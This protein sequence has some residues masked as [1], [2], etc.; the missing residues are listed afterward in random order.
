LPTLPGLEPKFIPTTSEEEIIPVPA[1]SRVI[2]FASLRPKTRFIVLLEKADKTKDYDAVLKEVLSMSPSA[3]D[4]E[5]RALNTEND[6]HE[7]KLMIRWMQYQLQS[8]SHFDLIQAIMSVFLREQANIIRGH[9]GLK[10]MTKELFKIQKT[11]W[12]KIDA[13]LQSNLCLIAYFT[14]THG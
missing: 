2:N 12:G 3:I 13:L 9:Q 11:E 5:I 7:L 14:N 10:E 8:H 1:E 4:F 6:C